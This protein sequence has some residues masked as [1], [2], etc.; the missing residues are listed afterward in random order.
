MLSESLVRT[1]LDLTKKFF[2]HIT[3]SVTINVGLAV[4]LTGA[5]KLTWQRLIP[6]GDGQ[7]LTKK[8][9]KISCSK[10]LGLTLD[11]CRLLIYWISSWT[12]D[13]MCF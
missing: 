13:Q 8:F 10:R 9:S 11:G 1:G 5:G 2:R 3:S 6:V 12:L 7:K 4:R